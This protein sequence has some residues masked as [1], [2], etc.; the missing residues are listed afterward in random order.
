MDPQPPK[1][2]VFTISSIHFFFISVL[3][4][5]EKCC[6]KDDSLLTPFSQVQKPQ[7]KQPRKFGC[8]QKP[9]AS[10][11]ELMRCYKTSYSFHLTDCKHVFLHTR[12]TLKS[13]SRKFLLR[14]MIFCHQRPGPPSLVATDQV[15][16]SLTGLIVQ[17][18]HRER[19]KQT[20]NREINTFST[21]LHD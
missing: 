2:P 20:G 8:R 4:E 12:L 17:Q 9:A 21:K 15:L 13:V 1:A 5:T 10:V 19:D 6:K 14:N 11:G 16:L 7:T 3:M 18:G